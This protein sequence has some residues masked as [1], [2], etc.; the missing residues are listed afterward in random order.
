MARN[1]D[2]VCVDV[3]LDLTADQRAGL[4][5]SMYEDPSTADAENAKRLRRT[6]HALS[7]E[8]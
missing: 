1:V 5:R 7:V 8:R 6:L 4:V 2:R 3:G